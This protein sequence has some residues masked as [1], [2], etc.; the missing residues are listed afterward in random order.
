M[1]EVRREPASQGASD[2][3]IDLEGARVHV[4]AGVDGATLATVLGALRETR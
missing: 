1:L 2:V 4:R 3:V